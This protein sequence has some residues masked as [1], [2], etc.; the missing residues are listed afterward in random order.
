MA[1]DFAVYQLLLFVNLPTAP[2]KGLG[3]VAGTLFAYIANRLWT[4]DRAEGG[5]NVFM[6]FLV[7]YV[8]TL[9][10]NIGVNSGVIALLDGREFAFVFGFLAATGTSATLNFVGMR[11]I[12]FR[13]RIVG[14]D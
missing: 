10:I 3:F 1:I 6:L 5:R 11:S 12:V 2:A 4:F 8:S 9:A 7:L 13:S 14:N